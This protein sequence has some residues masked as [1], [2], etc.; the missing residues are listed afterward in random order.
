M[1]TVNFDTIPFRVAPIPFV[2]LLS[3]PMVLLH[4]GLFMEVLLALALAG[5]CRLLQ[6]QQAQLDVPA[7]DISLLLLL[8]VLL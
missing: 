6:V 8:L 4:V 1:F 3:W 2:P 5:S 7:A